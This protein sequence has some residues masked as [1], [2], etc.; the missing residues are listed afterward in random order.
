VQ[1]IATTHDRR[2][3]IR[4]N[5]TKVLAPSYFAK[6]AA[7]QSPLARASANCSLWS[8]VMWSV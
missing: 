8:V 1:M 2:L 6:V 4:S 5:E 7:G 3:I